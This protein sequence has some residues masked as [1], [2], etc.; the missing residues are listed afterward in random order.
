M[1]C[2]SCRVVSSSPRSP[3]KENQEV[4]TRPRNPSK[5]RISQPGQDV[6]APG[7]VKK[8]LEGHKIV[9]GS[10]LMH[11]GLLGHLIFCFHHHRRWTYLWLH[12]I[13][14]RILWIFKYENW[15]RAYLLLISNFNFFIPS[16]EV[17]VRLGSPSK[18]KKSHWGQ[19]FQP[20]QVVLTSSK[21]KSQEVLA[22]KKFQEHNIVTLCWAQT[23][24]TKSC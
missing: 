16:Q 15:F 10:V 22:V 2:I 5:V 13:E 21:V 3:N 18:V 7:K 23:S 1:C 4:P 12:N 11:Q 19:K 8:S 9:L 17:P 24:R 20:G 14:E 6:A